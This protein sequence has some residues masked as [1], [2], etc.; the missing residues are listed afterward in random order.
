MKNATS[1]FGGLF[2]ILFF[3]AFVAL[4]VCLGPYC[5][6]YD[7]NVLLPLV[8]E[9]PREVSMWEPAVFICGVL[10]SGVAVPAAPVLWLLQSVGIL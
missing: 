10:F 7:L 4:V 1:L 3:F 2:G 6:A 9:T 8:K 5:M